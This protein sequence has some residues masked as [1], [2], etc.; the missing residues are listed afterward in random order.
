MDASLTYQELALKTKVA[1]LVQVQEGN[2]P[3]IAPRG[4]TNIPDSGGKVCIHDREAFCIQ[5]AFQR[6]AKG[7]SLRSISSVLAWYSLTSK[8][9]KPISPSALKYILTNPF[10]CGYITL[11]DKIYPGNHH[12]I[13]PKALFDLVQKRFD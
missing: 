6:A 2:I 8:T 1:R 4:Y 13:I 12:P 3:G 10:Y 5:E 9:G 11:N 7:Q